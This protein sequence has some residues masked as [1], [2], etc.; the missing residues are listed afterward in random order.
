M[1]YAGTR[2]IID[3]YCHLIELRD[4]LFE[5]ANVLKRPRIF[6][7]LPSVTALTHQG[8]AFRR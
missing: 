2:R 6:H 5:T 4:F 8:G 3:V 1:T 7:E